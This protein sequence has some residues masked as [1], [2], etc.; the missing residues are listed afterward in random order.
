[1]EAL[2]ANPIV[3]AGLDPKVLAE[4]LEMSIGELAE[5]VGVSRN[6]LTASPLGKRGRDALAPLVSMFSYV[7]S[8]S[9]SEQRALIWF[10]Y[11]PIIPLGPKP[12]IEHVRDG[13]IDDVVAFLEAAADGAYS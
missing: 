9:G 5:L 10:K 8:V 13:N 12:A 6:T 2:A 1:M 3:K 4:Q 7:I 11:T